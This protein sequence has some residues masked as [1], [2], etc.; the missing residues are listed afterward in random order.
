[1]KRKTK[2][3]ASVVASYETLTKPD[4][5][6]I[7]VTITAIRKGHKSLRKSTPH[8]AKVEA[9]LKRQEA[10]LIEEAKKREG[11][12]ELLAAKEA[13]WK[14][15]QEGEQVSNPL[16]RFGNARKQTKVERDHNTL[17]TV[18]SRYC[19]D[20]D[21]LQ[22]QFL[23]KMQKADQL[24]A[25]MRVRSWSGE[26]ITDEEQCTGK[27]TLEQK[28]EVLFGDWEDGDMSVPPYLDA[29]LMPLEEGGAEH[30]ALKVA[31]GVR[32]TALDGVEQDKQV[33]TQRLAIEHEKSAE[34]G[35]DPNSCVAVACRVLGGDPTVVP[36]GKFRKQCLSG[37]PPA[38][39]AYVVDVASEVYSAYEAFKEQTSA[40]EDAFSA[41][42]E[43]LGIHSTGKY[44]GMQYKV[45]FALW[46]Y[47]LSIEAEEEFQ[48]KSAWRTKTP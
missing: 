21:N 11:N 20:Y 47:D 16:R 19:E 5:L 6:G 45:A 33:L 37:V 32:D 43:Q 29:E 42:L 8:F 41:S 35:T 46:L 3:H 18:D 48:K 1:M 2:K 25:C 30:E 23:E 14:A 36:F 24:D 17:Y 15:D 31:E 10:E 7:G 12:E 26:A 28:R 22:I 13:Q 38:A 27:E 40:A 39:T 4:P 34:I 9:D 44:A